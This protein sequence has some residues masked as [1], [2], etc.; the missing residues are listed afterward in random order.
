MTASTLGWR[1]GCR[2]SHLTPSIRPASLCFSCGTRGST[3]SMAYVSIAD[4]MFVMTRV[5]LCLFLAGCGGRLTGEDGGAQDAANCV[6]DALDEGKIGAGA[7]TS[8]DGSIAWIR[9]D[10]PGSVRVLDSPAGA[11]TLATVADAIYLSA[12]DTT[13][14]YAAS[15]STIYAVSR[16]DGSTATLGTG[17][18]NVVA[19]AASPMP[20]GDSLLAVDSP[21]GSLIAIRSNGSASTLLAGMSWPTALAVADNTAYVGDQGTL[22][23]VDLTAGTTGILADNIGERTWA[24]AAAAD[25]VYVAR[26]SAGD[27]SIWR[28]SRLGGAPVTIV[29][30][31]SYRGIATS[32]AADSTYVYMTTSAIPDVSDEHGRSWLVRFRSDGS[33]AQQLLTEPGVIYNSMALTP[34]SIVIAVENRIGGL[35]PIARRLCK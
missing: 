29:P 30:N 8:A 18:G 10:D 12:I 28:L 14:V 31:V 17:Y 7:S 16:L 27:W 5:V 20:D 9:Q 25:Y 22:R 26:G 19:L 33:D 4:T 32:I 35:A 3:T 11:R 15:G 2:H 21:S 1:T 34:T 24:I 13:F 6:A 23:V